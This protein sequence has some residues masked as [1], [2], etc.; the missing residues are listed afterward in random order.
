MVKAKI[1]VIDDEPNIQE[2]VGFC[3]SNAGFGVVA[4]FNAEDYLTKPFDPD[5]LVARVRA[6]LR[7]VTPMQT[8]GS[9]ALVFGD[10]ALDVDKREVLLHEKP[11]ELTT[12]EFDIL[13]MLANIRDFVK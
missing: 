10:L 5:E 8:H 11:I 12:K 2:L 9:T 6:L 1:L 3:L 4:A 7:R 13:A